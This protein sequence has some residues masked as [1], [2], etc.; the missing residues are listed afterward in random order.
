V[1]SNRK[2]WSNIDKM[3]PFLAKADFFKKMPYLGGII[4]LQTPVYQ[5]L[6]KFQKITYFDMGFQKKKT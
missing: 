3:G 6:A 4:F 1:C 5:Q 2:I